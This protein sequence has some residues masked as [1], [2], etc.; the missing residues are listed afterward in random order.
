LL[1][2]WRDHPDLERLD[3][4]HPGREASEQ[5]HEQRQIVAAAVPGGDRDTAPSTVVFAPLLPEP[6]RTTALRSR[7]QGR[8]YPDATSMS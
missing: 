2:V 3:A 5:T 6:R 4:H 1:V 7:D 8:C